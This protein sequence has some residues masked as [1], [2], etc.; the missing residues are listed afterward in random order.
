MTSS[1]EA[2]AAADVRAPHWL[3]DLLGRLIYTYQLDETMI[4]AALHA[5]AAEV[6]TLAAGHGTS[7]AQS[8]RLPLVVNVIVRLEL[9][10][11]G[12]ARAIRDALVTPMAALDGRS[13]AEAMAGPLD[14]LRRVRGAIDAIATPPE[15]WWRVGHR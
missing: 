12:D 1:T 10:L 15:R 9:R 8:P 2:C 4:A 11:Q 13:P 5:T 6:I 14:Q 7:L 3:A